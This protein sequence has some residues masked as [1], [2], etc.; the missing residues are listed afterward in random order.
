MPTVSD[1]VTAFDKIQIYF[2]ALI[3]L[4]RG[5]LL[6]IA[7]P[8][9][10]PL[11]FL[12][13]HVRILN[14]QHLHIET[15]VKFED[16]CEIQG[17]STKGLYFGR[18]VTI[19][20]GVQIR[21][22]SYYGVGHIGYGFSIGENSSI[23]PGGFIGCAGQV[24]IKKNVMI[25]PNVT[26]IAENHHFHNAKKSIKEQGVY[27]KGVLIHDDVWIGANVTI[28]DGVTIASGAVIGAGA[29][30]TKDVPANTVLKRRISLK[31]SEQA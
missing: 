12:G 16:Y 18:N 22:S 25:G 24:Q 2:S 30:I 28:L 20:R 19:G 3:K 23:G 14:R 15:K 5:F 9:A 10:K 31:E 6:S 1:A 26:I 8:H 7:V 21:P 13:R 4:L 17:L 27:Q 11:I 29:I